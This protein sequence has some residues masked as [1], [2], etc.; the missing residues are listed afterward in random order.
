MT[1][2]PVK[3]FSSAMDELDQFFQ[4][5]MSRMT[6]GLSPAGLIQMYTTWLSQLA[7][8][9]GRMTS[10]AAFPSVKLVYRLLQTC[11]ENNQA[12]A[13]DPRFSSESWKLWPWN[14]YVQ[15]FHDMEEFW[16]LATKDISGMP[17]HTERAV[18]FMARQILDAHAPS[19]S[20]LT[21]PDLLFETAHS[22]GTN[23][24]QGAMNA[25]EDFKR[26]VNEQPP[27]GM[28]NFKPGEHLATTKGQVVFKNHLME[29]IQYEPVTTKVQKEPVLILPAWIMKYYILD[30]SSH[31]SLVKWL[32]EQGHQVFIVSWKNPTSEDR[33]LGMDDYIRDGALAAI[34]AVSS[35]AQNTPI[36]LTGYCLGG[37]LA[38]IAAA[39][40]AHEKDNRLKS[41]SL[42]AAQ[43]DF[44]EAGEMMV[45]VT[46]G[47]VDYLEKMMKGQ[48]YLDTKQM[49][50]A[51]QMLRSY[52]LVWSRMVKEYMMGQ[53]SELF[54]IMAWNADATRMPYKMHSEYL[55][56]LFLNNE[57]A[58]GNY[59]VLG[60]AIAPENISV[61]VFAVGTEKDH[62][63]PWKSVYKIH[64]M[65]SSEVTF[66][67][68][69]GGHNA[70]IVSEPGHKG[71]HYYMETKKPGNAYDAPDEWL[72][73]A[74]DY[75]GSWWTAWDQW[76][77]QRMDQ[78]E[79][80]APK[81]TGNDKF[82]ALYDAPGK[83]VHQI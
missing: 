40:M 52:D 39:Y 17:P 55:E 78:E 27:A 61:P 66:V 82:K 12:C 37:T 57:F 3:Q 64:L 79:I 18:S 5:K 77:K 41:L 49:A 23:L 28:E 83:Y 8:S 31:N 44:T 60:K 15:Y 76:L 54:D 71:R 16:D 25:V 29:L 33:N 43:G 32:T 81:K 21:N 63:A 20:M 50:G 62:V 36:H 19:N 72:E 45:F 6:Y 42:F 68:T 34:E 73:N 1:N 46:P 24:L 22:G 9:P 26:N 35:I 69:S 30:L 38:M 53:R 80:S 10:L 13:T 59:S 14:I 75:E 65:A 4:M 48:G 56:R 67:L 70:G 7:L 51:F 47:E 2:T 11:D 58:N 74:K